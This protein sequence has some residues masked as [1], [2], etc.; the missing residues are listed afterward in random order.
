MSFFSKLTKE[1][2]ELKAKFTDDDKPKETEKPKDSQQNQ[3][4]T[5]GESD[6]YYGG[7]APPSG[8]PAPQQPPAP[9]PYG[10]PPSQPY[11]APPG[12][13]SPYG[14]PGQPSPYGAPP[15]QQS[16]Y[17]APPGQ[18]SPYGA[19]QAPSPY[20]APPQHQYGAPQQPYGAPQGD[21]NRGAPPPPPFGQAPGAP[22]CP[23]G[24]NAQYDQHSQRWYYVEHAT[25]RTSWEPPS[26]AAVGGY[27]AAGN[28][29]PPPGSDAARA[30]DSGKKEKDSGGNKWVSVIRDHKGIDIALLTF[31]QAIWSRWRRSW[32]CWW[33]IAHE[34]AWYVHA[35]A[36]ISR[37]HLRNDANKWLK[38]TLTTST[39]LPLLQPLPPL[40]PQLLP[41]HLRPVTRT[42]SMATLI[43]TPS[44]AT[45]PKIRTPSRDTLPPSKIPTISHPPCCP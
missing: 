11:G 42:P 8:P 20:G 21:Y 5:R 27:G 17:G 39:R 23:P 9:S 1:F 24:W 14:A 12:Q 37:F 19:P 15:G 31:L 43:P 18:P 10:A 36:I 38:M 22:V 26:E 44:R 16:P 7:G 4:G 32:S 29:P 41:M 2:D 35:Q 40:Q 25:G 30:A 3:T 28:N 13:Q 34:C 6:S 33:R 45:R